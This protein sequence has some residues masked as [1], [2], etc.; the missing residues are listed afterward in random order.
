MPIRLTDVYIPLDYEE[1]EIRTIVSEAISV[2]EDDIANI[3]VLR[4]AIDARRKP[5]IRF[6][7]TLL[8]TLVDSGAEA[9]AVANADEV[10]A[11]IET[12]EA[13]ET[14]EPGTAG[15]EGPVIII[16]AGPA[17]L[18]AALRLA[19]AGYAPVV[20][21]RGR[22]IDGR[23]E[24]VR[25]FSRNGTLEPES[26]VVFGEG[27]AGAFSDGKLTHRSE[28]GE[29]RLVAET[30]AACGAPGDI[31]SD[32]RPHIGSD[33]LPGVV[34]ALRERIV[35]AGGEV[36]FGSRASAFKLAG[37]RLDK[38]T[39]ISADGN[40][41]ISPGAVLIAP[42]I[43][44]RDTWRD[45]LNG[46]I[47]L[48]ARPTLIGVR[49]EH[50]QETID[51]EQYGAL[52]GHPRLG[53][54]EYYLKAPE[55]NN[56]RRVH[57]FCM[58]PGGWVIPVSS[59]RGTLSANG[60]SRQAR[61][62]G[63]ANSALV[64]PV[65]AMDYGSDAPLAG[66]KFIE[67]L[68]R[69]VFIAGGED[70]SLPAQRLNDFLRGVPTLRL[71]PGPRGA[72]RRMACVFNLLPKVVVQSIQAAARTFSSTIRGFTGPSAGVYGAELRAGS[73]VRIVRGDDGVSTS[74][75]NLF[76]AGEGAGYAG[77]IMSSAVDGLRQAARVI[78][79]YAPPKA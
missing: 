65:G 45:L 20:I 13:P 53:A 70:Y 67:K 3:E 1:G 16:G 57:S 36:R 73:P 37:G 74:A 12:P 64:V 14:L 38:L 58:C 42:G 75:A 23:R 61:A 79:K 4:R 34:A 17:G 66:V 78:A 48:E 54:A 71:P 50:K 9:E 51:R 18:F 15:L 27:G 43:S 29:S 33:V 11:Q 8:V 47:D 28:S 52:A 69:D 24:D 10:T 46:G 30:L 77:G 76:P 68:E 31:T 63:F 21:E 19:E 55:G 2:G 60:M 22:A 32:A 7:F 5:N 40:E 41:E 72:R 44:A 49:V 39:I 35:A 59:E 6:V 26:N 56:L 25:A 62:S